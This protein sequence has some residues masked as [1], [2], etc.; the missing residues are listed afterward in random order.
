MQAQAVTRIM[1]APS[2]RST[3]DAKD[4]LRGDKVGVPFGPVETEG[5]SEITR[6]MTAAGVRALRAA[7]AM[8]TGDR[9]GSLPR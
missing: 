4:Y 7:V 9:G 5:A 2:S 8:A 1:A 6:A 3:P